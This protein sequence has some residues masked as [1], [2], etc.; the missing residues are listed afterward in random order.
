MNQYDP[1]RKCPLC[2]HPMIFTP[3]AKRKRERDRFERSWIECSS[4]NLRF[5]DGDFG[6]YKSREEAIFYWDEHFQKG[7]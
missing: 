2:G 7:H 1:E 5:G 6:I 3:Y 4:C